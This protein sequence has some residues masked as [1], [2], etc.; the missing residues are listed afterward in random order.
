VQRPLGTAPGQI[1]PI[2]VPQQRHA[3]IIRAVGS[4]CP[5]IDTADHSARCG[6]GKRL[7]QRGAQGS[8]GQG[9]TQP[10]HRPL[11]SGNRTHRQ[12]KAQQQKARDN[13]RAAQNQ[14][15]TITQQF[16]TGSDFYINII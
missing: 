11:R 12:G 7:H 8:L 15:R 1:Q 3:Q 5:R 2:F 4:F 14:E 6:F 10:D 16:K 9:T 13:A